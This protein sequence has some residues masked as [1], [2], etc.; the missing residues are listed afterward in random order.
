MMTTRSLPSAPTSP[1]SR[2]QVRHHVTNESTT[3]AQVL[4]D[5]F[6]MGD[7]DIA[8]MFISVPYTKTRKGFSRT[9]PLEKGVYLR[10]T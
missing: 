4:R 3:V 7:A 1:A 6:S 9:R 8:T 5:H 10:F 2:A